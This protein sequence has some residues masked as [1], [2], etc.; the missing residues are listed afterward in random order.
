MC[1]ESLSWANKGSVTLRGGLFKN[2]VFFELIACYP[3]SLEH[4]KLKAL[5]L[6]LDILTANKG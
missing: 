4:K 3:F 6:M 1:P 5:F 2:S